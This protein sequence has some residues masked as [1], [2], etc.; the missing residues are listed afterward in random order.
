[1]KTIFTLLLTTVLAL[2]GLNAQETETQQ[3][4]L[5]NLKV[6]SMV[7]QKGTTQEL[8][9]ESELKGLLLLERVEVR[10]LG[11]NSILLSEQQCMIV[12]RLKRKYIQKPDQSLEQVK[13]GHLRFHINIAELDDYQVKVVELTGYSKS[14]QVTEVLS[15]NRFQ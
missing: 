15:F 11:E 5:K 4:S 7:S 2:Q 1:M 6:Y 14:G 3:L 12:E 9:L 8:F 13:E 10:L